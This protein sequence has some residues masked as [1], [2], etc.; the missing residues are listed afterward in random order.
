MGGIFSKPKMKKPDPVPTEDTAAQNQDLF[1]RIRRR[2]GRRAANLTGP[3]GDTSQ[4][5]VSSKKLLGGP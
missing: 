2:R 1:D 3:L 4:P 5:Q